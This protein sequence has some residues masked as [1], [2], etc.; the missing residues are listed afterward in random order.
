MNTWQPRTLLVNFIPRHFTWQI[1][2]SKMKPIS[3]TRIT[4]TM[5][6]ASVI[7]STYAIDMASPEEAQKRLSAMVALVK[8]KGAIKASEQIMD[9]DPLKCRY[10][11]M[12]C[13]LLTDGGKYL[14]STSQP[15]M[16]GQT[17]P[18]DLTDSDGRRV[19]VD[20]LG[21]A[22]AGKMSWETKAKFVAPG[23]KA[24]L[25]RRTLCERAAE[26]FVACVAIGDQ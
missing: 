12:S 24:I 9:G 23:T 2:E 11:D 15:A 6:L 21:P 3:V 20:V 14:V 25:P 17:M 18:M 22:K 5:L 16:V 8:A 19:M 26:G 13:M 4:C 10:K 7:G 1:K